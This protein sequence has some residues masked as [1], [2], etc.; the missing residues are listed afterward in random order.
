MV[1]HLQQVCGDRAGGSWQVSGVKRW[2][3]PCQPDFLTC[4]PLA[5]NS[6]PGGCEVG[7]RGIQALGL[8]QSAN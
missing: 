1:P 2:K 6:K 8:L 7:G 4:L 3:T 5:V